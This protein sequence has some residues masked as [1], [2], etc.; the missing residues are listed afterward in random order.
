[1]PTYIY[2]WKFIKALADHILSSLEIN[3]IPDVSVKILWE[4]LK[5]FLTSQ[6]L[7]YSSHICKCKVQKKNALKDE[8]LNRIEFMLISLKSFN[9]LQTEAFWSF[10]YWACKAPSSEVMTLGSM[11]WRRNNL[12]GLTLRE[13]CKFYS[14]P[15]IFDLPG[16]PS[17]MGHFL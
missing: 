7:S 2:W 5:S 17:L 10:I 14:K 8:I 6:T 11:K 9:K 4:S 1:M 16:D 12:G 15:Y 13:I 3:R